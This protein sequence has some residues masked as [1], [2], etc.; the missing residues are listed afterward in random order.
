MS[1]VGRPARIIYWRSRRDDDLEGYVVD[2]TDTHIT[3]GI[4]RS[5][6][7]DCDHTDCVEFRRTISSDDPDRRVYIGGTPWT[8]T[9]IP[10]RSVPS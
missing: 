6:H 10:P 4:S 3:I 9:S 2:E 5:I 1:N 8:G 7:A